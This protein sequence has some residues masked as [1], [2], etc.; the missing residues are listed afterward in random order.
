MIVDE[1]KQKVALFLKDMYQLSNVGAGGN[2]TFPTATTLD[3]PILGSNIA[4]TNS[5][6]NDTTIDF[7]VSINGGLLLGNTIRELGIFSVN[8]PLLDSDFAD[9][10]TG[11]SYDKEPSSMLARVVFDAIGPFQPTDELNFTFTIEVE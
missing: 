4:T 7:A 11:T 3:S 8:I 10:R 1:A 6:S 5:V 2:A 9:M